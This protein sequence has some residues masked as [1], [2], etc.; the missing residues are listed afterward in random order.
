VSKG[1]SGKRCNFSEDLHVQIHLVFDAAAAVGRCEKN[2]KPEV[3]MM[4]KRN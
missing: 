3:K 2:L 4:G 1:C